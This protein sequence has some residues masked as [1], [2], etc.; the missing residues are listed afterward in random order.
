[1]VVVKNICSNP[2][3]II[4]AIRYMMTAI[5]SVAATLGNVGPGLGSVGPMENYLH[6]PFLGKWLL[7]LCMLI[8][9]LEIYTVLVF[10]IP[11]FWKK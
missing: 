4:R 5:S 8:G 9:R 7:T 11:A 3:A 1:M 2:A 10:F 6:L